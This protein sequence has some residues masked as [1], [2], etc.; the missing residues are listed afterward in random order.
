MRS[1]LCAIALAGAMVSVGFGEPLLLANG[2]FETAPGGV[3]EG[4]KASP[5]DGATADW[6]PGAGVGG[7]ACL[8]IRVDRPGDGDAAWSQEL[9][10][11]PHS[12]YVLRG[13]VKGID[14]RAGA[15][16]QDAIG[17]GIA[18]SMWMCDSTRCHDGN[19]GLGDFDW[20]PF[21]LDFA[22]GPDGKITIQCRLGQGNV[23]GEAL[24]D[25]LSVEP[26]PDTERFEG[27]H[28]VL[29]LYRDEVE[30]A[31][32]AGVEQVIANTDLAYE[33]YA[34]LTG[35]DLGEFQLSAWGPR[36]WD[37]GALG[38]SGNPILW[39][40]KRDWLEQYWARPGF[41]PEVFLHELA[42]DYDYEP[43]VFEM[44]FGEL[45]FY[46]ACETRDLAIAEDG[47]RR[48][49]AV[50]N[51]WIVRGE[52]GVPNVCAVVLKAI[53]LRDT[54]GW[55]P[56]RQTY[57]SYLQGMEHT[58]IDGAFLSTTADGPT[59]GLKR[60]IWQGAGGGELSA[61]TQS[62]QFSGPPDAVV[63]LARFATPTDEADN[64]GD[65]VSGFVCPDTT[66]DY[67]L[68]LAS[69]DAG[70]LWLSTDADP[71]NKR[72]I[73]WV[74]GYTAPRQVQRASQQ[75]E[76]IHL[77]AG[78]RYYVEALHVEGA[79]GD[80]LSVAWSAD[81]SERI[82]ED[83]LTATETDWGK[84][85]LFCS[86]L[87]E[88]SGV[89]LRESFTP[90]ELA[91]LKR[92]WSPRPPEP[93]QSPADVPGEV[94]S[95]GLAETKWESAEVGWQEPARDL[96]DGGFPMR[97]TERVH[98][99]GLYAHAPS[100]YVFDLG[101]RWGRLDACCALQL[102][103]QGSVVFVVLGDGTE[104]FRSGPVADSAERSVQTD[105]TG[106]E[107]LE[108]VGEDGGNG[109]SGDWGIWFSPMLSR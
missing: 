70:G 72:R 85:E 60:E 22:T 106:V 18:T 101:G 44:H 43:W 29:N 35:R 47:W 71:T 16:D 19:E 52:E 81:P 87:A 41:C 51:R 102:G 92:A 45:F 37:I 34:E 32:R 38:W 48:G 104:L 2:N 109:R 4:W 62:P 100:R 63:D 40:V 6:A 74:E 24:F 95:V 33:A 20:T 96:L 3:P 103:H 58:P 27:R 93:N 8:R 13:M 97:S 75:S 10:L 1:A 36:L 91:V 64:Y 59:G 78:R 54:I 25:D 66:G 46:Y 57:R 26:N 67:T 61:L 39:V 21:A 99:R 56:F 105:L 88:F 5:R 107:T 90:E 68:W 42:H 17:A 73:A 28:F 49:P 89:D 11:E 55:E 80:H 76:P 77:E 12:V 108:L 23:V 9:Q 86:R 7:S 30:A 50:R 53:E 31:T 84:F 79:G 65:R 69:D 83:R 98:E 14:V 15:E 94:T 82:P